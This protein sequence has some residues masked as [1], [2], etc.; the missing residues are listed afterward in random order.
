MMHVPNGSFPRRPARPLICVYS[1][2]AMTRSSTP[3]NFL[4]AV[5]TTHRA[6]MFSPIANV[7]V[8]NSTLSRPSPNRISTISLTTGSNPEWW[9]PMPRSS[10]GRIFVTAASSRSSGNKV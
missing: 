8:A 3:S 1:P 7:S 10:T 5:N 4:N 2:G 9:I 6:G